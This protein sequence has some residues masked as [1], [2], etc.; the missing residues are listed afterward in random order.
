MLPR[1]SAT[2]LLGTEKWGSL[3]GYT[4]TKG[5][6]LGSRGLSNPTILRCWVCRQRSLPVPTPRNFTLPQT[7]MPRLFGPSWLSHHGTRAPNNLVPAFRQDPHRL[8]CMTPSLSQTPNRI[9]PF[10]LIRPDTAL[11]TRCRSAGERGGTPLETFFFDGVLPDCQCRRSHL[12]PKIG[13]PKMPHS[14]SATENL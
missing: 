8:F 3:D 1:N 7:L 6:A 2:P 4:E 11:H 13:S 10:R 12:G 9:Q 5:Y 14:R